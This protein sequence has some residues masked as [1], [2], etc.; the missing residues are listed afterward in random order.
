[1][2]DTNT[3]TRFNRFSQP[4]APWM[5]VV[6][7]AALL[8]GWAFDFGTVLQAVTMSLSLALVV[9][10]NARSVTTGRV[11]LDREITERKRA[12]EKF[13]DSER[14]YRTLFESAADA[15]FLMREDRFV[16]CNSK[17]L[18]MFGCTREQI[19]GADPSQFSPPCQ[20]NGRTSREMALEKIHAALEDR[21]QILEWVH[22]KADGTP[23][24]AEVS[25]NRVELNSGVH[26]QAIVRDITE[27]KRADKELL[28]SEAK[29]RSLFENVRE[30]VYQST[31]DGKLLTV[32][33]AFVRMFGYA[34]EAEM[35][36]IDIVRDLYADS[37]DREKMTRSFGE[38]ND[39]WGAEVRLLKKNGEEIL[40]YENGRAVRNE[41]GALLYYEGTLT[42]ITE[43][44][45]AEER[46][47]Q[48]REQ[49]EFV[50]ETVGEGITLSDENGRFE[51][52]N[53]KMEEITGYSKQ[54]AS[55]CT[56]FSRLIY[57]TEQEHQRALDGL[58]EII[59]AK[60]VRDV[61]TAIV[62]KNGERKILLVSTSMIER[63]GHTR[64]LSAYRDITERKHEEVKLQESLSLLTTTLESTADGILVVGNQGEV[65][66]FNRK[67][68]NMWCIPESVVGTKDDAKLLAWVLD[69]LA[70]P[71][72]FLA[73]V[74]ELYSQPDA[75]SDDVL[76]FKDGRVFERFSLP[77][78][79]E[80]HTVG[81]VWNF[82][83]VTERKRSETMLANLARHNKMI[84]DSVG[85]GILGV[86]LQGNHTFVNPA[87]ARMLGY[88][89]D[90][91]IGRSSHATWHHTKAD[92]SPH[93]PQECAVYAALQDG[94][95]HRKYD[96]MFW[97]KDGT[98]FPVEFV[99]TP[100]LE[101][102]CVVGAVVTFTDITERRRAEKAN[103]QSEV[104]FRLLWE[105]NADGLRLIDEQGVVLMANGAF[106]RMVGMPGKEIEGK[107]FSVIYEVG[108]QERML[109]R[110]RERFATRTVPPQLEREVLLRNGKKIWLEAKNSFFEVE[111]Q[112]PLL[113]SI[114][115]DITERKLAEDALRLSEERYRNLI[116]TTPDGV[117]KS[118][119]DGKFIEVNPA[120][121][122]ILGYESREEL[123]AIDI[124]SQ[125]YFQAEDRES[126]AL[127]EKLEELAMFRLR[128]K[129]G[130]EIWVED[131]GRH[132]LGDDG[133]VLYH[134]G[135]MRDVSERK[136]AEDLLQ[137]Q[138]RELEE[139]NS[140]LREAKASAEEQSKLLRIQAQELITAREAAMEASRLKSEFLANMSHEI[141]TPMNGIIGMT[142]LLLDTDLTPEQ[143]E[144]TE[145][146][147]KSGDSL[148]TVINDILDFSKIEAGKL[149]IDIIDVDLI[150]VVEE[151]VELLAPRAQESGLEL[152]CL[153]DGDVLRA[154]RCDPGRVRQVLTNLIGNAIKFTEEGEITVGALIENQTEHSVE[155]RFTIT[156]TGIGI[157]D[158][159]SR[160]LFVAFSQAD[161]STTRRYGGTGLG[162]AICKQLV[163]L[164]NGTIG[165]DSVKGKGST[166]WWTATFEKQPS[167]GQSRR[168]CA[169]FSGV[170]CLIVDD[171]KVNRTIVHHY[172]TS[173][174]MGNG[175]A[176]NGPR[177][178]EILRRAASTGQPYDLA[179][180]DMQMPGMDGLQLAREIK[181]DPTISETRLILL[182]SMGN[183]NSSLLSEA[184]F[185]A[186]LSKPVRQSQMFDCIAEVMADTLDR[187]A[188]STMRQPLRLLGSMYATASKTKVPPKP[189]KKL[190]ILVAED[191][192]VNQKV[193]VRILEKL[194]Y[195][196]D[197]ANDGAKAVRSMSLVPYDI[198]FMDC[199]MPEM[200]GF[201]ATAQI[202]AMEG[203]NRHTTIIAMTANALQGDKEKC[204]A[205]G[206]DDYVSKPIRQ[207]DLAAAIDRWSA[208]GEV[209]VSETPR[210]TSSSLLVDEAIMED[211]QQL[212][213]DDNPDIVAQL[214]GMF[215]QD[216]PAGLERIKIAVSAGDP[217]MLRKTAHLLKGSCKQL[218]LTAMVTLCQHVE[219]CT[220]SNTQE[221]IE[222]SVAD[223]ETT[224]RETKDYLES[225]Y[226]SREA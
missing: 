219:T 30:G 144:F 216:F 82:R 203:S 46:Q 177:A 121:I 8:I 183:R 51:V 58:K 28:S 14:R 208:R 105:N 126:A 124:K 36:S 184:G 17:T 29:F 123:L 165:V 192:F 50:L 69:Q 140:N 78:R 53:S 171:I 130:S 5:C 168:P 215:L 61:E 19:I 26:L 225:K 7:V 129:D 2:V 196:P 32:N 101:D 195:A 172:I 154:V 56:D 146:V 133:T 197:V 68:L 71:E 106:C 118:S 169:D 138:A 167:R 96:E 175:A 194:G 74:K 131:H 73:K 102:G 76:E 104:Q 128:K 24:D 92:G 94:A 45:R 44:K 223:L 157:S 55:A 65:K 27:R 217:E 22:L 155:V 142:S 67:F 122:K 59:E 83:D 86:D 132:V 139:S 119:H 40:V 64:F 191:N 153:I 209:V 84:L 151:T 150:S 166:F 193:A 109:Y 211:L 141:R 42:D 162:L 188:G 15:I 170:Q 201:E 23:F 179:I 186:G 127:E 103:H 218:G 161:G 199:Q 57:P 137:Q 72:Q 85:E 37:A 148:L 48:Q 135:I 163:E 25:L 88:E 12:E 75:H 79:I 13:Q 164:M 206:M 204:L 198:I 117:Y 143:R 33:P 87:A 200:D 116:E 120:M 158:E 4:T 16:D 152:G 207:S 134:E 212:A 9:W 205:A 112:A 113:L 95:V 52:F 54:E 210:A 108:Q 6:A 60:E 11:E 220:E 176:E 63:D 159:A 189:R 111:G 80:G 89:P 49:L 70:D 160:R 38:D 136:K 98:S 221:G 35:L 62:A 224:F 145:I 110:H 31:P 66:S 99:S 10:W 18:E 47:R 39:L 182:T 149:S 3:H 77:Q 107:P 178:L 202:R 213:D 91:L 187:T 115:R 156:D 147:R 100:I 21:H 125:L 226:L 180:I 90:E 222:R 81:R 1:M 20:P 114:F 181:A 97:R 93:S 34:S 185:S 43:R 214:V 173:W 190:Q 174:G 41:D